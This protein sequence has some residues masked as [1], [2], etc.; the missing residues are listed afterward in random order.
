M[1]CGAYRTLT[2][3]PHLKFSRTRIAQILHTH[4]DS[5]KS[6]F[7][8]DYFTQRNRNSRH[9]VMTD[10]S[11]LPSALPI[12]PLS[13]APASNSNSSRG[14]WSSLFNTEAMRQLMG[15]VQ[16][17][18]KDGLITQIEPPSAASAHGN[19][20]PIGVPKADR[21]QQTP[22]PPHYLGLSR[23]NSLSSVTYTSKSWSDAAPPPRRK[24]TVSFSSAGHVRGPKA[25]PANTPRS[26]VDKTKIVVFE[27]PTVDKE[28]VADGYAC[29][30]PV[31]S[32]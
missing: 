18:L 24:A 4:V 9:A 17:T 1:G 11:R 10:W 26:S 29:P 3:R 13:G 32:C 21:S 14:S 28:P 23:A 27:K 8:E 16:D 25:S 31:S 22:D 2:C 15:G 30:M 12:S 20:G 19:G 5:P 6:T 7:D